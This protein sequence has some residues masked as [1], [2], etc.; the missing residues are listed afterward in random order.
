MRSKRPACDTVIQSQLRDIS[1]SIKLKF[2]WQNRIKMR[3]ILLSGKIVDPRT[4]PTLLPNN[5]ATVGFTTHK[6]VSAAAA[7]HRL[8]SA[9][10]HHS[11][12]WGTR[13]DHVSNCHVKSAWIIICL[14]PAGNFVMN[15]GAHAFNDYCRG[16]LDFIFCFS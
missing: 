4:D 2:D 3:L 7:P 10:S 1:K 16:P 5:Q 14:W 8:N 13:M 9:L 15:V 11:T 6:W 12:T